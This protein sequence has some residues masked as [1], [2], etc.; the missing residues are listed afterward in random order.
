MD[1]TVKSMEFGLLFPSLKVRVDFSFSV[2]FSTLAFRFAFLLAFLAA[3]APLPP[4]APDELAAPG[5]SSSLLSSSSSPRRGLS[6]PGS[7]VRSPVLVPLTATSGAAD[8][9]NKFSTRMVLASGIARPERG[10]GW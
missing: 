3:L 9:S 10:M 7:T 4:A 2:M 5:V 8:I 6:L 1:S